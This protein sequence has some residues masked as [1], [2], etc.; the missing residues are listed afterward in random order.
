MKGALLPSF[1]IKCIN[2]L[3]Y[4]DFNQ[5]QAG[6]TEPL[7]VLSVLRGQNTKLTWPD[8]DRGSA[9][10]QLIPLGDGKPGLAASKNVVDYYDKLAEDYDELVQA[11]G[12][13]MPEATTEALLK[14]ADL[15]PNSEA[16]ILDLGCG[17]GLC[18]VSLGKKGLKNLVGLDISPK[19][20]KV[21]QSRGCYKSLQIADLLEDLPLEDN[22]FEVL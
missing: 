14:H 13:F 22:Q 12:Y 7:L 20:L 18:G 17:N 21:A 16:S 6:S 8:L 9:E 11:W 4:P 1:M 2:K 19:S 3:L 5:I 15:A 10:G